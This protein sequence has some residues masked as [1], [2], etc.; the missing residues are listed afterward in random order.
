MDI[1]RFEITCSKCNSTIT[2]NDNVYCEDCY[3][4]S[5]NDYESLKDDYKELSYEYDKLSDK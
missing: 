3:N 1:E 5:V 2:Y 4:D